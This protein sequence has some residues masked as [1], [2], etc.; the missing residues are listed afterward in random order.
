MT[1]L[2]E[3]QIEELQKE[4]SSISDALKESSSLRMSKLITYDMIIM[5][6]YS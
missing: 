1:A 3:K 4:N 2:L 6:L 5:L